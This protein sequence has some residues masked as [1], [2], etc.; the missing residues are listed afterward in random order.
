MSA[1]TVG[2]GGGQAV[3][4]PPRPGILGCETQSPE[5]APELKG[6]LGPAVQPLIL[7]PLPPLCAYPHRPLAW[8]ISSLGKIPSPFQSWLSGLTPPEAPRDSPGWAWSPSFH[9]TTSCPLFYYTTFHIQLKQLD[10]SVLL[11]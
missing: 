1:G 10:S 8:S 6:L 5:P 3:P 9:P 7:K 2:W 11:R 4:A